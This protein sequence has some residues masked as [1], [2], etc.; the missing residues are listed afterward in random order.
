MLS[1]ELLNDTDYIKSDIT[2]IFTAEYKDSQV[3]VYEFIPNFKL[4]TKNSIH[5]I[6]P[7]PSEEL[8]ILGGLS[9]DNFFS[10]LVDNME[11]AVRLSSYKNLDFD[12][13][14]KYVSA[15]QGTSK[16]KSYNYL[17]PTIYYSIESIRQFAKQEYINNKV[18][19]N[20]EAYRDR[21]FAYIVAQIDPKYKGKRCIIGYSHLRRYPEKL[22]IPAKIINSRD[23]KAIE[24]YNLLLF[25]HGALL[26]KYY[27][28]EVLANEILILP[29]FTPKISPTITLQ[30]NYIAMVCFDKEKMRK[31]ED[32]MGEI[33]SPI[34]K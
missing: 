5:I 11:N 24:E 4:S 17:D 25:T 1:A 6:L 28:N 22:Y 2:N 19:A 34:S 18:L 32:L 20:L 26:N 27:Q 31:N 15:G 23:C 13:E 30:E 7:V 14:K 12:N 33:C 21:N 3:V 29:N 9:C 16:A 10:N 8:K